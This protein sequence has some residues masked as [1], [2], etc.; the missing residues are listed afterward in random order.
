ME[1]YLDNLVTAKQSRQ[2]GTFTSRKDS[3]ET[4]F[5]LSNK[6]R[7]S[8]YASEKQKMRETAR[9]K[10]DISIEKRRAS[11][12]V[13]PMLTRCASLSQIKR[14]YARQMKALR[15]EMRISNL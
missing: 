4:S 12:D 5:I 1:F 7:L 2:R 13:E 9:E 10:R 11:E 6:K 8:Q 14:T 3:E 15:K